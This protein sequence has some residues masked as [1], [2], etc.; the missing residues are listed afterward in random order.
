M[1]KRLYINHLAIIYLLGA[2][3]ILTASTSYASPSKMVSEFQ[4][5]LIAVM[6]T[7]E[8]ATV[9]QRYTHLKPAVN[10]AF[11]LKLMS[12]IAT[13]K[14]WSTATRMEKDNLALAFE[15]ASVSTLAT[16]FNG[17]SGEF[18]RYLGDKPGPQGTNI[19]MTEIVK[20]D[21]S[22][23]SINY[24]TRRFGNDW[25]IIDIILDGGISE[26]MV[27]RSEYHQILKTSGVPGLIATLN[28]KAD[29]LIAN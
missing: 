10:K 24:I 12:Q 5:T 19:V 29:Y 6:K 1:I 14:F 13:G 25:K 2:V 18:F 3:I 7:A 9:Q 22:T 21:E 16:L 27:R 11:H 4:N 17:Y 23:V 26:L 28:A 20:S 8:S 15:R